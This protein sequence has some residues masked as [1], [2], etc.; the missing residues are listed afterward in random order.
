MAD[1]VRFLLNNLA[2]SATLVV[3][4]EERSSLPKDNLRQS[5]KSQVM[6]SAD[7]G[8]YS[9]LTITGVLSDI[10]PSNSFVIGSHNF[11]AG[12]RYRLQVYTDA[13]MA[14]TPAYDSTE[15][16]VSSTLAVMDTDTFQY[17][18]PIWYDEVGGS[19][20]FKL[21]LINSESDPMPYF[22]IGRLFMGDAI[23]TNIGVSFGH[24]IYWKESTKQ[25]RT[26]DGTLRSDKVT[27]SKVLEFSINTIYESER[28]ILQRALAVAGKRKDFFIS[29]FPESCHEDLQIDYSG[30]VKMTKIPRYAEF[31]PDFYSAKYTVEEI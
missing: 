8:T 15:V 30:I 24:N 1:K 10:V 23:S 22:Q 4:P 2:D 16:T 19:A 7:I 13:A 28:S 26:E 17:N 31:A 18:I 29:L 6:R 12:T 11:N 5:S 21:L 14:T 25:Y 9:T 27:S 20:A 3:V